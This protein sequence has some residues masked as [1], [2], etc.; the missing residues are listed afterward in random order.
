MREATH[1]PQ[2]MTRQQ[3]V[4]H[5]SIASLSVGEPRVVW[6]VGK[7]TQDTRPNTSPR[8]RS[9]G[10]AKGTRGHS[11]VLTGTGQRNRRSLVGGREVRGGRNAGG[12]G[13]A[14]RRG[15]GVVETTKR[16]RDETPHFNALRLGGLEGVMCGSR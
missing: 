15:A 9:L 4:L 7:S 16:G 12:G 13:A 5:E 3:D 10:A 1:T 6:G 2:A 14:G 11:A 8:A